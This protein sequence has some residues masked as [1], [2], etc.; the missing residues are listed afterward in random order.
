MAKENFM[1]LNQAGIPAMKCSKPSYTNPRAS[2][3]ATKIIVFYCGPSSDEERMK[4]IGRT[5]IHIMRYKSPIANKIYY[6]TDD[7]TRSGHRIRS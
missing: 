7:Q 3:Q 2:S 6:K 5:L 1:A 4:S